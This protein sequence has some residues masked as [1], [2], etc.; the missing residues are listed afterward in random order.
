MSILLDRGFRYEIMTLSIT[1]V[2]HTLIIGDNMISDVL[3]DAIT[4]I[5]EYDYADCAEV[6]VTIATMKACVKS[7]S[8]LS[9]SNRERSWSNLNQSQDDNYRRTRRPRAGGKPVV[10]VQSMVGADCSS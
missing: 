8:D 10:S 9:E 6:Q 4:D 7:L 5:E 1:T 2:Y 3:L